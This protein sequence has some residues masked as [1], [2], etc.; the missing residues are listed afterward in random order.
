MDKRIDRMA[1]LPGQQSVGE[2]I[3][4][5]ISHGLGAALG[6]TALVVLVTFAAMQGDAMRI[7]AMSVYGA[8][9]VILFLASTLYHA[10]HKKSIKQAFW[11]MDHMAIYLLIAG[12]Y[13]PFTLVTL[14][15]AWGWSIF[16]VVWGIAVVGMIYQALFIGRHPWVSVVLYVTMGW[17]GMIAVGPLVSALPVP[18]MVLVALGGALY[19]GGVAFFQWHSLKYHHFIWHLFVLGGATAHVFAVLWYVLPMPA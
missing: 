8:S 10:I 4:N 15:G 16:G 18:G 19:T 11:L 1:A 14:G 9:L 7:V 3:A 6:I 12:T 5:A 17:V 13:T 2:E